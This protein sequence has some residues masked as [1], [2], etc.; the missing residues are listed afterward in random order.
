[1]TDREIERKRVRCGIVKRFLLYKEKIIWMKIL[2]N[3]IL[4][5]YKQNVGNFLIINFI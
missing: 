5:R 2:Q 4:M 1:M 3:S